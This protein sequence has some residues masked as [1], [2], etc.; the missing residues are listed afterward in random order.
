M[1]PERGRGH[2]ARTPDPCNTALRCEKTNK[3][4]GSFVAFAL[5]LILIK[6]VHTA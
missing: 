2:C 6:S 4:F 1:S 5:G 3:N